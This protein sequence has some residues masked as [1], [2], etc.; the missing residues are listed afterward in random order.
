MMQS[1][2]INWPQLGPMEGGYCGGGGGGGGGGKAKTRKAKKQN[3]Q[4]RQ[5]TSDTFSPAYR[6]QEDVP[7]WNK[8]DCLEAMSIRNWHKYKT[9]GLDPWKLD[10]LMFRATGIP[11]NKPLVIRE[12]PSWKRT[13]MMLH[14]QRGSPLDSLPDLAVICKEIT[15]AFGLV[16]PPVAPV[17]YSLFVG[18]NPVHGKM[19]QYV[20]DGVMSVWTKQPEVEPV[21]NLYVNL[22]GKAYLSNG[23]VPSVWVSDLFED[24]RVGLRSKIK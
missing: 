11:G 7:E 18:I 1:N 9:V 13:M 24:S 16:P 19:E 12:K 10:C 22:E 3:A 23:L 14:E 20:N 4:T 6:F 8:C 21:L 5:T 17:A 15:D 2:M